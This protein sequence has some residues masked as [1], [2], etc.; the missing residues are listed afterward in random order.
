MALALEQLPSAIWARRL[1]LVA[2]ATVTFSV[3]L[4][5]FVLA[6]ACVPLALWVA[7]ARPV[8]PPLLIPALLF[9]AIAWLT[10]AFNTAQPDFSRI[11]KLLWFVALPA[12]AWLLRD[13]RSVRDLLWAFALGCAFLAARTLVMVPLGAWKLLHSPN[14]ETVAY[15]QNFPHALTLQGSMPDGQ[16][17]MLGLVATLGLLLIQRAAR[18]P[19][20]F[21][22]ALLLLQ[23]AG[24]IMNLK[25]GS[26]IVA[27]LLLVIFVLLKLSWKH[28]LLLAV[29]VAG[30][31][32]LPPV[33]ARL[34]AL[35]R[36]FN[37]NAGGRMTMWARVAPELI[38]AHPWGIG[39]RQLTNEKMRAV[40]PNVERDRDH[41]HNNALTVL[42]ET[43]WAGLA[44]YA[45]WMGW[46][47]VDA[48][49][50]W[51]AARA[52]SEAAAIAAL[53]LLLMFVGLL[54]NGVVEYN[55]GTSRLMIAAGVIMG[56]G[57]PGRVGK[58]A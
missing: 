27:L 11:T 29:I 17:L 52:T 35:E 16:M 13:E 37:A 44:V 39:Y 47:L 19:T 45:L 33:R 1:L 51:R 6:L 46:A 24:F 32:C 50:R 25:R 10:L 41:L 48:V 18:Q 31:L 12:A 38:K 9:L 14:P 54:L 4:G 58:P 23:V 42:V 30:A 8:L 56:A 2:V 5:Q 20:G 28:V 34:M 26:W 22:V 40:A 43:G 55:F 15:A 49:R 57:V 53:V 3:A 36:D 21:V 7:R